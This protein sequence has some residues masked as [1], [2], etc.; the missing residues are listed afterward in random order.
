MA[1]RNNPLLSPALGS[2]CKKQRKS[3]IHLQLFQFLLLTLSLTLHMGEVTAASTQLNEKVG[4]NRYTLAMY[5]ILVTVLSFCE[6][7]QQKPGAAFHK[8]MKSKIPLKHDKG[9]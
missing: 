2:T 3:Q 1:K 4:G 7:V 9:Q 8:N 5:S 6:I